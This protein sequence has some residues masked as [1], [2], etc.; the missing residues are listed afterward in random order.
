MRVNWNS[1][2][3]VVNSFENL[4]KNGVYLKSYQNDFGYYVLPENISNNPWVY[5]WYRSSDSNQTPVFKIYP[6][7]R[8]ELPNSYNI[9][10]SEDKDYIILKISD[11]SWKQLFDLLFK[12]DADYVIN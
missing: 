5:V 9:D 10:Y 12:L 11:S 7:G 3:W 2:V 8:L 6:D 1:K 4:K